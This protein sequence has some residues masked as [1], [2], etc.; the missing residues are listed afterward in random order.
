MAQH[1]AVHLGRGEEEA[2]AESDDTKFAD[3]FLLAE[4]SHVVDPW[5]I[6]TWEAYRDVP[7]LGRRTRL[8]ETQRAQLWSIFERVRGR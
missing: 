2:R 7:R 1:R 3:A 4:W 8:P 6:D 5:R